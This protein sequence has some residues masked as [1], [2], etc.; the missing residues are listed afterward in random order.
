[1]M[2]YEKCESIREIAI[3]MLPIVVFCSDRIVF[4]FFSEMERLQCNVFEN[5]GCLWV[6][7]ADMRISEGRSHV[8]YN[9]FYD[10]VK[11]SDPLLPPA[12][13][14]AP[15]LWPQFHL[16]WACPEEAQCG[17]IEA[18]CRQIVIRNSEIQKVVSFFRQLVPCMGRGCT[19]ID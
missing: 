19:A 5:C 18:Q 8:H 7:L 4:C 9:P 14:L 6:Y 2:K 16:R 12:A 17:E 1:M 10:P 3:A 13:A 11:N 15:T